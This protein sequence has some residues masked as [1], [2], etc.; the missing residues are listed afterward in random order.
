MESVTSRRLSLSALN[1]NGNQLHPVEGA[2][3]D[4]VVRD[5]IDVASELGVPTVVLMS[6][7]PGARGEKT[8]N[9]ITTSWP[10]ETREV[11]SYQWDDV[12][13]PYWEGLAKHAR[14]RGAKLAVPYVSGMVRRPSTVRSPTTSCPTPDMA[15][16]RRMRA[17]HRSQPTS[18]STT[19][20]PDG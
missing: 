10:P 15:G 5:A 11:L 8:P 20:S 13:I 14:A 7:L 16:R 3:H 9:W 2:Q 18:T 19:H 17:A 12:A 1:A 6:G 4:K